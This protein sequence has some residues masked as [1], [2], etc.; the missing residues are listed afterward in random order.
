MIAQ[1]KCI[2]NSGSIRISNGTSNKT[3]KVI[4]IFI[5]QTH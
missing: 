2:V 4:R 5:I 3:K 1:F